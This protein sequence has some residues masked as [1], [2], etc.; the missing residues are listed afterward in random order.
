MQYINPSFS[1]PPAKLK[2]DKNRHGQ[3][4]DDIFNVT[5]LALGPY[6]RQ[7]ATGHTCN[8]TYKTFSAAHCPYCW[9]EHAR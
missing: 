2:D 1:V 4:W 5:R 9:A 3:T 8:G 7:D 6:A